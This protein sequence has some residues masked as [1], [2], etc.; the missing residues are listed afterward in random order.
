MPVFDSPPPSRLQ[1]LV[2]SGWRALERADASEAARLFEQ[3]LGL[4]RKHGDALHG[5][6]GACLRLGRIA[7]GLSAIKR[8]LKV[9]STPAALHATHGLLEAQGG[10]LGRARDAFRRAVQSAP[11][12]TKYRFNLA[13]THQR[14]GERE[15]AEHELRAVTETDP[16]F[17]A[18]WIALG[19]LAREDDREAE[20]VRCHQ[21]AHALAPDDVDVLM[22][23]GQSARLADMNALAVD[24]FRKAAEKASDPIPPLHA[25]GV[26]LRSIGRLDEALACFREALK[27]RPQA[28][29]IRVS[30]AYSRRHEHRDPDVEWM[31]RVAADPRSHD[32][33]EHDAWFAFSKV[34]RDLGER[35]RSFDFLDRAN[36]A[37]RAGYEFSIA[38]QETRFARVQEQLANQPTTP[39]EPS[40]KDRAFTPIFVIGMPRSGTTLI[41]QILS[42]HPEVRATGEVPFLPQIVDSRRFAA[43]YPDGLLRADGTVVRAAGADYVERLRTRAKGAAFA[44]DK[45]LINF[46]YLAAIRRMLPQA[47]LI[48][49]ARDPRDTCLSIYEQNFDSTLPYAF[50]QREV[51]RFHR[52]YEAMMEFWKVA[53]GPESMLTIRYED[54]VADVPDGARR[55]VEHCGLTWNDACAHFERSSRAVQT[56]SVVQVRQPVYTSSVGRW[57]EWRHRIAP[58][59]EVLGS[60]G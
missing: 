13:L 57:R 3:A 46:F 35:E 2:D 38:E 41:E 60:T 25:L 52:V 36:A 34:L 8:A 14:L 20:A 26:T 55:I 50:D 32:V 58:M 7:D 5:L 21:R 16:S 12:V 4:D 40:P 28:G 30:L 37:R 18:A 47:K 17:L 23:L 29:R 48:H 15:A 49:C 9:D 43:E 31:E 19:N 10:N 11:K 59:L 44:T 45:G 22:T 1:A 54:L 56:A 39:V 6:A 51:A 24:C 42:C 33:S 27:H 53:F